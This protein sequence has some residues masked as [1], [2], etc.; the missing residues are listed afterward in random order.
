MCDTIPSNTT[1]T[2]KNADELLHYLETNCKDRELVRRY[3]RMYDLLNKIAIMTCDGSL[4]MT[5]HKA[6]ND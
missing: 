6:L 5:A 3:H 2:S 1:E 4:R